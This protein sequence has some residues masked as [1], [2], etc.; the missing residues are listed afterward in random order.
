VAKNVDIVLNFASGELEAGAYA[1]LKSGGHYV[2]TLQVGNQAEAN[3]L[4]IRTAS[5]F[6]APTSD[7]LT[8]AAQL[9]DSGSVKV[10]VQRTFPL[11][12]IQATMDYHQS[13]K[14]PG[15]VVLTIW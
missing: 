10:V 7:L 9:I 6:A 4:G 5:V 2:T 13:T 12:E 3:R 15:K 11:D 1:V 8:Q 14:Q